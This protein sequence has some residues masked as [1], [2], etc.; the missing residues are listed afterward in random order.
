MKL[1]F[2]RNKDGSVSVHFDKMTQGGALALC[3]GLTEH[4]K[5]GSVVGN[6]LRGRLR[7]EI[8]RSKGVTWADRNADQEL[9]NALKM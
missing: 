6:D 5:A 1:M 7:H 8:Q 9:F 2:K 4:V 3:H